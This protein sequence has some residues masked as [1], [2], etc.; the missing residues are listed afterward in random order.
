MRSKLLAIACLLSWAANAQNVQPEVRKIAPERFQENP[1]ANIGASQDAA[2]VTAPTRDHPL[3][4]CE[5]SSRDWA[6]C[7]RSTA[8]LSDTL[9]AQAELRVLTIVKNRPRSNNV[10]AQAFEKDMKE[11]GAR[12]LA[13]REI[14]CGI[15][16]LQEVEIAK[17][18]YEARLICQIEH[19]VERADQL[20]SRY[21]SRPSEIVDPASPRR[22]REPHAVLAVEL[23]ASRRKC[24]PKTYSDPGC[25]MGA[26][27]ES[28]DFRDADLGFRREIALRPA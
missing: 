21:R 24:L 2:A 19:D 3:G 10:T 23:S 9:V 13:L 1:R 17:S 12:W 14:E 5:R 16:A 28:G 4:S 8:D 25:S 22:L 7:L 11:A 26:L 15:L 18:A 6:F 27:L 20:L